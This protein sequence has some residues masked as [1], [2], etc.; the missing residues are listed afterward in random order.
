[1]SLTVVDKL[2]EVAK[3]AYGTRSTVILEGHF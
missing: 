3:Y 1:M 2:G